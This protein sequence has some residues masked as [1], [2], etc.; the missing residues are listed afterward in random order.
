MS[1]WLEL[2]LDQQEP[3]SVLLEQMWETLEPMLV[4]QISDQQV[5]LWVMQKGLQ[6]RLGIELVVRRYRLN[7]PK[8]VREYRPLEPML[9][10]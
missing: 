4:S 10:Q 3:V 6:E 2:A 5:P 7:C 9:D 1:D 8:W